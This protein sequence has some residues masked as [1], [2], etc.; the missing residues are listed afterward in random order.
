[1]IFLVEILLR[2][3]V[4]RFPDVDFKYGGERDEE[5]EKKSALQKFKLGIIGREVPSYVGYHSE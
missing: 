5:K 1:M 2:E 3:T 4:I